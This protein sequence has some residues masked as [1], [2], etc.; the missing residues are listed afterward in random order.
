MRDGHHRVAASEMETFQLHGLEHWRDGFGGAEGGGLQGEVDDG[1]GEAAGDVRA[2]D[3]GGGG[4]GDG[5]GD[6]STRH[7]LDE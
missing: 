2:W 5:N 1:V 3:A 6:D 4:G 7:G